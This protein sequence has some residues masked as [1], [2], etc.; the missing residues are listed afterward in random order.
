MTLIK[1]N[2]EP[3]KS[4]AK[5]GDD[6]VVCQVLVEDVKKFTSAKALKISTPVGPKM[7]P[8]EQVLTSIAFNI[9]NLMQ[10]TG[11]K[12][13]IFR[14]SDESSELIPEKNMELQLLQLQKPTERKIPDVPKE[15]RMN[16]S[17]GV[18]DE[19]AEG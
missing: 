10:S 13:V 9:Y 5:A 1:P 4:E 16:L 6:K 11:Q 14:I 2:G 3:L 7:V 18:S 15:D 12:E 19:K 8:P 17:E